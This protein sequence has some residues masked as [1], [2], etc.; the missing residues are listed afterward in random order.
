MRIPETT[1]D[2]AWQLGDI[3]EFGKK[4]NFERATRAP[5]IVRDPTARSSPEGEVVHSDA[6]VEFVSLVSA[7]DI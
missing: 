4:T 7:G 2:H 5:F 1:G 6:L 3:G